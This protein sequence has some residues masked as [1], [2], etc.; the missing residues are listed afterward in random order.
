MYKVGQS[1]KAYNTE[2]VKQV[3][4][5][6][7]YCSRKTSPEEIVEIHEKWSGH[8]ALGNVLDSFWQETRKSQYAEGSD[9]REKLASYEKTAA[10]EGKHGDATAAR[11]AA[12][13]KALKPSTKSA[14]GAKSEAPLVSEHQ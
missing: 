1:R 2:G 4:A 9:L 12:K 8:E 7:D 14:A 6:E 11:I 10:A 5:H 13:L 3:Q